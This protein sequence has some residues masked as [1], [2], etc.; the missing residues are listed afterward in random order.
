L[1]LAP[2]GVAALPAA[3]LAV[4]PES[5]EVRAVL[6]K[7]FKYLETAT[8]PRLGGKCL[9]A[10]AFLKDGADDTHPKVVEALRVCQAVT[11]GEASSINT[12]IYSTGI[13]I[14]F[15][16]TLNPSKHLPEIV[17]FRD[18]L[19]LRQKPHGGWG[20]ADKPTGDTSMTQYGLLSFWEM[21]TA[22]IPISIESTEK[23]ANWLLRTQGPE[24]NW[25]YQGVESTDGKPVKQDSARPGMTAAGLG[26]TYI[27]ADILNLAE[28]QLNA[29]TD[30][31]P[32]LRRV[33][34]KKAALTNRVDPQKIKQ[35]QT[36]GRDW[37]RKNYIIDPPG[38]TH[39][40]LYALERY[41]SFA[42][43][44]EGKAP[45]EPKWYND[46]YAYLKR[47]QLADGSW[48]GTTEG[49]DA[50]NTA[51]SVLFLLRST[52]KAIE[53]SK[54]YG[55]G[56][57]LA[58]RGLPA[59]LAAVST[60]GGQIV[61]R[62]ATATAKELIDILSRPDDARFASVAADTDWLHQRLLAASAKERTELIGRLRTLATIGVADARLSSVE[63]LGLV[64]DLESSPVLVLALD[65]S[66]WRVARAADRSLQSIARQVAASDLGEKPN[67]QT[68]ASA[69]TRWKQWYLAVRPDAEF[70]N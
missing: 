5:P 70:E 19:Q 42:E 34:Q 20:Y 26:C 13:S 8:E 10:L 3:A 52:K 53:K 24:G 7:A 59:D 51:F 54:S 56:A 41:Q 31:P 21:N 23:V 55:D 63:V 45:K 4:T 64:R 60:R 1:I 35:A 15:L 9:I 18:S 17:K 32:A 65:D 46:G 67:G 62:Q 16:C 43:A 69:I 39:Y 48:K 44:S 61:A 33:T 11:R 14:I 66:D 68:R 27:A 47:E 12:D 49:L 28:L 6:K 22:G 30:L 2:L 57:L 25:G 58:G 37:F 29:D 36:R 40:Y 50:V 38:F